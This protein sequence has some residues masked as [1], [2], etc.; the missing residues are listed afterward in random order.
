MYNCQ[1]WLR[2]MVSAPLVPWY[3]LTLLLCTKGAGVRDEV[4]EGVE[5]HFLCRLCC[6]FG[7]TIHRLP[8]LQARAGCMDDTNVIKVG[9]Q[10][11]PLAPMQ[12]TMTTMIRGAPWAVV[13]DASRPS[14]L[15][16]PLQR[17]NAPHPLQPGPAAWD[18]RTLRH[19]VPH[20]YVLPQ[21]YSMLLIRTLA[22][23]IP[24][25]RSTASRTSG[26]SCPRASSAAASRWLSTENTRT[27]T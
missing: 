9:Q 11:W 21:R 20:A 12:T 4:F 13:Q 8:Q 14:Q 6:H 2:H 17:Y 5:Q 24:S 7:T 10:V 26:T 3:R 19:H 15:P 16:Y 1:L 18:H 23:L 25:C 27:V 22:D